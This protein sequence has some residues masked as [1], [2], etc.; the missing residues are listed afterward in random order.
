[1]DSLPDDRLNEALAHAAWAQ[2]GADYGPLAF[3]GDS[4]LS[5]AVSHHLYLRP[6]ARRHGAGWLTKIRAQAVSG[7]ACA[8]VAEA[9]ELPNRMER[10]A[11]PEAVDSVRSLV[12]AQHALADALEA[13]IGACYLEFGLQ[14]TAEAVVDAFASQV[15][16]ALERPTDAK[17]ELQ[18]LLARRGE[19]VAYEVAGEEGPPHDRTFSVTAMIEQREIGRGTGRSKKEAEQAAARAALESAEA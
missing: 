18:E 8:Q 3:L 9:L 7:R 16:E 19:V 17:S 10:A 2:R 15:T 6:E 12:R 13:V 4:V 14:R 1:M 5:L 11:P